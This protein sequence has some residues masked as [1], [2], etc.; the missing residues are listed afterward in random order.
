MINCPH[1][2]SADSTV[3]ETKSF[4]AFNRRYRVCSKCKK[5]YTTHEVL[6]VYAGKSTGMVEDLAPT[7]E[8]NG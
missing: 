3:K 6:A 4:P 8:A 7:L 5:T 2:G 1:C